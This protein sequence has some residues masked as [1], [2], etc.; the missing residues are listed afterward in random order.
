MDLPAVMPAADAALPSPVEVT[1]GRA[2]VRILIVDDQPDVLIALRVTLRKLGL[3]DLASDSETD[4]AQ[5]LNL[6]RAR[7]YDLVIADQFMDDVDGLSFLTLMSAVQPDALRILLTASTDFLTAQRA[8][9]E[10]GVFRYLVKPWNPHELLQHVRVPGLDEVAEHAGLVDGPLGGE[11]VGGGGQQDA[12]RVGLN[13]RH[14]REERQAVDVVHE[15]VGDDDVV[16]ACPR[17]VERLGRIGLAVDGKVGKPE[18]AQRDAQRDEHVGL[19][20]D[21]EDAHRSAAVR[22]L[23]G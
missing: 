8:I 13:G 22:H 9:N 23:H 4:P 6:A 11:E 3:A 12:Q 19:I 15:L 14:Q 5:A 1:D 21:D 18:P 16:A 17:Q 20:I 2:P 7:R 10:A